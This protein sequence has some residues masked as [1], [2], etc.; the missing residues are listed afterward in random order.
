MKTPS[1]TKQCSRCGNSLTC[2]PEAGEDS[3]WCAR[4]P[5]VM[6]LDFSQDCQ[7]PTC[8]AESIATRIEELRSRHTLAEMVRLA[9]PYR[10][11][12]LVRGL[13]YTIEEGLMVFSGWYHL[14]RGSCCGN[15]C[16]HCPYP[17]PDRR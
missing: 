6:P 14:K 5:A 1:R 2:G 16:R 8:L 10:N 9:A 15:G 11:S 3:C 4:F 7:C 17:R 12:E 13:D